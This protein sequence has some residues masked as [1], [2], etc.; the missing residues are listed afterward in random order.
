MKLS[1]ILD[2]IS[3]ENEIF[4]FVLPLFLRFTTNP[5]EEL[6]I[7]SF[8]LSR[9]ISLFFLEKNLNLNA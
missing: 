8:G 3:P 7:G 9:R 4:A 6:F 5:I 2:E 1:I